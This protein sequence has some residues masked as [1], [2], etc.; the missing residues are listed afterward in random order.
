MGSISLRFRLPG[1][2]MSMRM[3]VF[4]LRWKMKV[5]GLNWLEPGYIRKALLRDV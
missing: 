1:K 3:G 4:Q 5:D 2:S